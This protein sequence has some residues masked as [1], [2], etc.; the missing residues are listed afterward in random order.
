LPNK[1][2]EEHLLNFLYFPQSVFFKLS[3]NIMK[4]KLLL[5]AFI[6][7]LKTTEAQSVTWA[8]DIAPILYNNCTKCH[9]DGGLSPFSLMSYSQAY[10]KRLDIS[11]DV[12]I[13]KMPPWPPD[14]HYSRYAHERILSQADINKINTWVTAGAPSGDTT[15]A[16][17]PPVYTNGSALGTP[18]FSQPIQ[19]YTVPSNQTS[20]I[21][22][23]FVIPSGLTQD[24]FMTAM[25]IIPGNPSIVHHVLV[26]Q[27]T[28]GTAAQLDANSPGPGYTNFGGI[29][30]N[31]AILIGG[32][33]P[34]MQPYFLPNNMGMKIYKNAD[35]VLQIHYPSASNSKVDSTRLNMKLST[36]ISRQVYLQPILNHITD[37]V[38][39]PLHIPADSIKT[40]EEHYNLNVPV[41]VSLLSVGPHCHL[42][43]K[44]WLSYAVTPQNDTIPL[45][46]INNWDFHWQGFYQFRNL[47][48]IPAHSDLFGFCTYDNTS[49]NDAN[50]NTPPQAVSLGE[51]TTDEM[52]LIYFAYT[53]YQTGDENIVVDSST[54][55]DITD[56]AVTTAIKDYST[57]ITTPQLY[58][59]VPNP[60]GN[61][62]M[63]SYYLPSAANVEWEI[64]D[65]NGRLIDEL[66]SAGTSGFN[67]LHYNTSKL[68][69]GTYLYSLIVNGNAKSKQLIITR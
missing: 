11:N 33:V 67:N 55:V 44:Q 43:G 52:M 9:H 18:D 13:R 16:S 61:E 59:A 30:T 31:K 36:S 49:N 58:D 12:T 6:A 25:E 28:T 21:Y 7:F 45:I 32:W 41:N 38:N 54:L 57:I 15:T 17:T 40:F 4:K 27:D 56:T 19:T 34:G 47:L 14:P 37:I 68:A 29:G 69:Q 42:L 46:K 65:L 23:C 3:K 39:G 8:N 50:P 5:F 64:F 20:D 62:T 48:K 10:V 1:L 66:K 35:I 24:E 63:L 60:A 26:Y 22:Q 51:A 53:I 2:L